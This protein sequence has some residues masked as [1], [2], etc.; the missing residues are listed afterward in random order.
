MSTFAI[1]VRLSGCF[2]SVFW[3]RLFRP[4]RTVLASLSRINWL[5]MWGF[6]SGLDYFT[7]LEEIHPGAGDGYRQVGVGRVTEAEPTSRRPG[8]ETIDSCTLN[9]WIIY[10]VN[11]I[12]IQINWNK[13]NKGKKAPDVLNKN[14][15]KHNWWKRKAVQSSFTAFLWGGSRVPWPQVWKS[16]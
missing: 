7:P 10:Y 5:Q 8:R 12:T 4:H 11:S 9:E 16:F 14:S 15:V 1:C 2:S 13:K 3:N 6:L